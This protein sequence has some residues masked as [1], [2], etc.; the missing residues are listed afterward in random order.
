[1][2]RRL[3][4]QSR[5]QRRSPSLTKRVL[6]GGGRGCLS[7]DGSPLAP[8]LPEKYR[9]EAWQRNARRGTPRASCRQ[10][11]GPDVRNPVRVVVGSLPQR[12]PNAPESTSGW[13]PEVRERGEGGAPPWDE[14]TLEED[15]CSAFGNRHRPRRCWR[16]RS[17]RNRVPRVHTPRDFRHGAC[18]TTAFSLLALRRD[19][20][21]SKSPSRVYTR[22][23]ILDGGGSFQPPGARN[24]VPRV[25]TSRDFRHGL[26]PRCV[27]PVGGSPCIAPARKCIP[28]VHTERDFGHR[29]ARRQGDEVAW[30]EGY[31]DALAWKGAAADT[32]HPCRESGRSPL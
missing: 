9:F 29:Q 8:E 5:S 19:E 12:R 10:G 6:E 16:T 32:R 25:H 11:Q 13:G 17:A 28:R 4:P 15:R 26:S 3:R 21:L 30:S 7:A 27:I 18:P 2:P 14:L 20:L 1:V 24:R 22:C 31:P 23:V